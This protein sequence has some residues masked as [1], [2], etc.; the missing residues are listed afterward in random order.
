MNN[1][2]LK[3]AKY[4]SCEVLHQFLIQM[5]FNLN[6]TDN[7]KRQKTVLI[8]FLNM[9]TNPLKVKSR[10]QLILLLLVEIPEI[11]RKEHVEKETSDDVEGGV[12]SHVGSEDNV[13]YQEGRW[14]TISTGSIHFLSRDCPF[15]FITT[16]CS[17]RV[18]FQEILECFVY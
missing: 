11:S 18:Q 7:S 8:Y 9:D 15:R 6:I 5:N 17:N 13:F 4:K 14:P 10:L 12:E 16:K 1:V 3:K 2:Q